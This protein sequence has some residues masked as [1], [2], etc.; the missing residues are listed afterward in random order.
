MYRL[1]IWNNKAKV[2]E[3]QEFIMPELRDA[4]EVIEKLKPYADEDTLFT[5]TQVK[6]DED[7][8]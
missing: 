3:V 7:D 4:C 2:P 5:V 1:S 8:I 6:E